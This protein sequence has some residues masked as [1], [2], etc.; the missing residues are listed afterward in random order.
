[1]DIA[2]IG[3][4]KYAIDHIQQFRDAGSNR[5]AI[6]L[7]FFRVLWDTAICRFNGLT[8][9]RISGDDLEFAVTD[10]VGIDQACERRGMGSVK[11]DNADL[12]HLR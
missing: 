11:A 12:D 5:H 8:A 10:L 6:S 2:I 4:Q 9:I 1:M 7:D 3:L